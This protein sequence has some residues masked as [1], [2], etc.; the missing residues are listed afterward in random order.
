MED[1]ENEA[2][3]VLIKCGYEYQKDKKLLLLDCDVVLKGIKQHTDYVHGFQD[4]VKGIYDEWLADGN[5]PEEA[6]NIVIKYVTIANDCYAVTILIFELYLSIEITLSQ[7]KTY[8]DLMIRHKK[9]VDQYLDAL[10]VNIDV[11]S[12]LV[13][14]PF[15]DNTKSMFED[16]NLPWW[17]NQEIIDA[18]NKLK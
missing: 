14:T 15:W 16:K 4:A 17:L 10:K 1:T 12:T 6:E 7:M 11:V 2:M 9:V 18:A 13:Y 5:E 8:V 3:Q